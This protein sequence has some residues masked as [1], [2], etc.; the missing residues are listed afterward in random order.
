MA[1][2]A[3]WAEALGTM[4]PM[5]TVLSSWVLPMPLVAL[6]WGYFWALT[7][8]IA[9]PLVFPCSMCD[10]RLRIVCVVPQEVTAMTGREA[11]CTTSATPA[12]SKTVT[13]K[14]AAGLPLPAYFCTI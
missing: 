2:A 5:R 6:P 3:S 9:D 14:P 4:E 1:P 12:P 8:R 13:P 11:F 10:L 7:G